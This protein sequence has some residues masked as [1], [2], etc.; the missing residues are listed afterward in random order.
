MVCHA[1]TAAVANSFIVPNA[2][3]DDDV[4]VV[5]KVAD[6]SESLLVCI[7]KTS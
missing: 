1:T 6:S 3:L 4:V 2:N 5:S 7:R